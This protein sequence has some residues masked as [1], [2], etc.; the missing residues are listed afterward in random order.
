MFKI[1][2]REIYSSCLGKRAE[3]Q[4]VIRKSRAM[5]FLI[6]LNLLQRGYM[7]HPAIVNSRM[8]RQVWSLSWYKYGQQ[9]SIYINE[10]ESPGPDEMNPRLLKK[11]MDWPNFLCIWNPGEQ[12]KY[13]MNGGEQCY[14]IFKKW[15]K[16]PPRKYKPVKLDQN[17]KTSNCIS[18]ETIWNYQKSKD[19]EID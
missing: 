10:F 6:C 14:H 13:W 11:L 1:K 8:K 12:M 2:G 4:Q 15:G 5:Q 18:L 3:C 17:L 9:I 7:F 16:E 19:F